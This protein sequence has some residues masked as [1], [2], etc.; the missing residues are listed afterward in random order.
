MTENK[1]TLLWE[2]SSDESGIRSYRVYR[3]RLLV[4]SLPG[5][6]L[7]YTDTNLSEKT[8]YYFTIT[9]CDHA[10]NVSVATKAL[11]ITTKGTTLLQ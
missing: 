9:A 5:D 6:T 2:A 8:K 3:N 7:S 10:G 1:V 4:G 11:L